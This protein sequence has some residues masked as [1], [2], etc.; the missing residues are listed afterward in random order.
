MSALISKAERAALALR[1]HANA[2][3]DWL[4]MPP[5]GSPNTRDLHAD[6]MADMAELVL[7]LIV[8]VETA[9]GPT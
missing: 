6:A 9:K 2:R 3:A 1:H 4:S 5:S 8:Q 7:F